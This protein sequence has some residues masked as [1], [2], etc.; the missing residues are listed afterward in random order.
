MAE[1]LAYLPAVNPSSAGSE[2]SPFYYVCDY[3]GSSISEAKT[4]PN[5]TTYGVLY[6][7]VAATTACPTGWHLPSDAEWTILADFL[8]NNGYGYGGSSNNI[9]KSMA[10]ASGWTSYSSAGAVGNNQTSNNSSGF[11]ALP[12]GYR[13][14]EGN[15]Y[16]LDVYADFWSSSE[17]GST[18]WYRVLYYNNDGLIRNDYNR[19]FGVAVRCLQN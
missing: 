8:T 1:N 5:Y 12:C 15:F 19:G 3:E 2:T 6:N 10:S 16:N 13:Y 11:T 4:N 7:W 17:I 14:Y 18:A 9:G